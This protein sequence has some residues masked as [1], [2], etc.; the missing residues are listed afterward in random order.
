MKRFFFGL[1]TALFLLLATG[2]P[3]AHAANTDN[4]TIRSFDADYFLDKDNEGRAT[5]KTVE[6]ITASGELGEGLTGA[7]H[8]GQ[9]LKRAHQRIASSGLIEAED[10]A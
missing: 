8:D 4:F 10:V 9:Y 6:K 5:L 1:G 2:V 7:L 3:F